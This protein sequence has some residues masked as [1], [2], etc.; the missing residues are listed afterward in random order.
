MSTTHRVG[1]LVKNAELSK[2]GLNQLLLAYRAKNADAA[3]VKDFT[4]REGMLYTQVRA[5]SNRVNQ[6]YDSWPSVELKKSYKTFIGKPVFVNH[7]N[8]D[9]S[10]ARGRVIAARYV[11]GKDG[12]NYIEVVQEIDAQ[13]FPKL[14]REIREGGLDSVSMGVEAGRTICSYCGNEAVLEKDF[15]D[16]V[17][18]HKGMTLQ[19]TSVNGVEDVLVYESCKDLHFFELSYV[20]DPADE[21]AVVSRV[22]AASKK[23]GFGETEAPAKVDTLR[24]EKITGDEDDFHNYVD[25]PKEF[26]DPDLDEALRVDRQEELGKDV[27]VQPTVLEDNELIE[28]LEALEDEAHSRGLDD[29]FDGDFGDEDVDEVLSDEGNFE[30][31]LLDPAQSDVDNDEYDDDEFRDPARLSSKNRETY[32]RHNRIVEGPTGRR[33]MA[34]EDDG[35]PDG[36]VAPVPMN[37]D[38]IDALLNDV[39]SPSP[40]DPMSGSSGI[41]PGE[42]DT[43]VVD[44]AVLSDG[45]LLDTLTSLE[46][47]A[48]LRGLDT[49]GAEEVDDYDSSDDLPYGDDG[50]VPTFEESSPAPADDSYEDDDDT[51]KTSRNKQTQRGRRSMSMGR[52]SLAQRGRVAARG[53]LRNQSRRQAGGPLV[54]TGDQSRNDQGEW[55]DVFLSQTPPAESVE[56]AQD[57]DISNTEQN[58]VAKLNQSKQQVI[59]DAKAY[60]SFLKKK[61]A[62][63]KVSNRQKLVT[64]ARS[65]PNPSIRKRAAQVLAKADRDRLVTLAKSHP[66]P[67]IR[68]RAIALLRQAGD[69]PAAEGTDE[70][71]VNP[72]LS[73]TDQQDVKG[74]DFDGIQLDDVETQPKDASVNVFK[75]FNTWLKS[76]SGKTASTHTELNKLR[77][78]AQKWSKQTGI[79]IEALFPAMENELRKSRQATKKRSNESLDVAA[80]GGRVDVEKPVAND[81][82]AEAQASQF[83]LH[84]F[85]DNAGDSIADPDLSTDH[86]W[87]P[88]EGKKASVEKADPI[89]AMRC[90]DQMVKCALLN[91]DDKYQKTSELQKMSRPMVAMQLHLL[92]RV[93]EVIQDRNAH[94][95]QLQQQA[96]RGG[97]R[98]AKALPPGIGSRPVQRAASVEKVAGNDPVNSDMAMWV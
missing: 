93:A 42:A 69:H 35:Y 40:G 97:T 60:E 27:V 33:V 53:Q 62:G 70:S 55:E 49:N 83:D 39:A 54:D 61:Q 73:G 8:E 9:P 75:A 81:T 23:T 30:E 41:P 51:K 94:I 56:T 32:L 71:A 78:Y 64:I 80:P 2:S 84:D 4:F 25:P 7:A 72:P 86:I 24:E 59:R 28:T 1:T 67:K 88:E 63:T 95:E 29:G 47:E 76:V 34:T 15:C 45:E 65:H 6:N 68:K 52:S 5:I 31:E 89:L 79:P 74:D 21:T 66:D 58:L 10:L 13:R 38:S 20:F 90:A 98:G 87:Y 18:F 16:H 14:A 57:G 19:R 92:E 50:G 26:Q 17:L 22:L 77:A 85:G 43:S 82:D 3:V 46:D 37:G 48:D 96:S 44:P 36:G 91:E 12:D 11:E